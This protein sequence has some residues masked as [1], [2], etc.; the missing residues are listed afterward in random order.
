MYADKPYWN[1]NVSKSTVY[2]CKKASV[3]DKPIN[4]HIKQA[5]PIVFS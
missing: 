4:K 3:T 2:Y 1:E 5:A